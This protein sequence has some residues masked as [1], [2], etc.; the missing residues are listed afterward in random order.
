MLGFQE[1]GPPPRYSGSLCITKLDLLR[2]AALTLVRG[3]LEGYTGVLKG[4][5]CP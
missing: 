3:W 1:F 5:A 4:G 2:S